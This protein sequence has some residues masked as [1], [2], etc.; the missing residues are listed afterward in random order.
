MIDL[1]KL[2]ILLEEALATETKES[3]NTWI[4]EQIKKDFEC[5]IISDVEFNFLSIGFSYE[6]TFQKAML[7]SI[8]YSDVTYD[9]Y[10]DIT[11][12]DEYN[13]AA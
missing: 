11:D 2:Q 9:K 3:L 10:F 5:G 1:E 6:N 12:N 8:K 13:L 7:N 4:D